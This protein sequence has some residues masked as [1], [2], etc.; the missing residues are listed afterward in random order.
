MSHCVSAS[1]VRV[2]RHKYQEGDTKLDRA[3]LTFQSPSDCLFVPSSRG[4]HPAQ[5][6]RS[7]LL[8]SNL[9]LR[10]K[11]LF[12]VPTVG[13]TVK[14]LLSPSFQHHGIL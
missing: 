1:L 13:Q 7:E 4:L 9:N 3:G 8:I 10:Q 6:D 12:L 5:G 2:T 14:S 11:G